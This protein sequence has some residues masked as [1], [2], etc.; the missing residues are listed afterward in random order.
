[1]TSAQ[2]NFPFYSLYL[3]LCPFINFLTNNF[4]AL[5][6]KQI[7]V[8]IL[9][10]LCLCLFHASI[11]FIIR[12]LFS[13][14]IGFGFFNFG[15]VFLYLFFSYASLNLSKTF[16]F[17]LLLGAPFIIFVFCRL[18]KHAEKILAFTFGAMLI[19][20]VGQLAFEFYKKSQ[21]G[22]IS[23]FVL[24]EKD[25]GQIILPNIYL[26][27]LDSYSRSDQLSLL[28]YD[29]SEFL[30]N[31]RG[32]RFFVADKSR[33]NYTNSTFSV[34]ALLDMKYHKIP[35]TYSRK[36]EQNLLGDNAITNHLKRLGYYHV[37]LGP[38]QAKLHDCSGYEDYCLF[39]TSEV[40]GNANGIGNIFQSIMS[41]SP[42]HKFLKRF[43]PYYFQRSTYS[44]ASI[45]DALREWKIIHQKIKSPFF[46]E[47][48]VWQPHAP[49]LFDG[50]C[51]ER[52]DV[53]EYG[54]LSWD[55]NNDLALTHYLSE[56]T[57]VNSQTINL[58][59][60]ILSVDV[61]PIILVLSD[62]GHAFFTSA[63]KGVEDWS[64]QAANANS[65]TL[66]AAR[67]P[68]VCAHM[69]Y[70]SISPVNTFRIV[71][72]CLHGTQIKLL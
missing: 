3:I 63:I 61:D 21:T 47:A 25:A 54:K 48:L 70:H 33:S 50:N 72:S 52:D 30:N 56:I 5:N 11:Y 66:W 71:L 27:I 36:L 38:N 51:N 13:F 44:K 19:T 40:D 34:S 59:D 65:S 22:D 14:K 29:N 31:L 69:P 62:H 12:Y 43:F 64:I 37:R 35:F 49:Y 32:R 68:K 10:S 67:L 58:I 2:K 57:C 7:A 55:L 41:M 42:I 28:G 16:Y 45:D 60:F 8:I 26:V 15:A 18:E 9:F 6:T 1:M 20:S 23:E 46:F 24:I 53:L 39:K 4:F 17:I